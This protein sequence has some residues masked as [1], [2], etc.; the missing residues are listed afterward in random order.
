MYNGGNNYGN[1]GNDN[2]YDY[3]TGTTTPPY[4][5]SNAVRVGGLSIK[6]L[7]LYIVAGVVLLLVLF[8]IMRFLNTSLVMHFGVVAG[9]LLLLANVRELIGQTYGRHNNTALLNVLIGSSL[10]VAWLSQFLGPL[11]WIPAVLLL[12]IAAPLAIGRASVYQRYVQMGRGVVHQARRAVGR[13][14]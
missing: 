5:P 7:Y 3:N 9:A 2:G 4:T 10:V 6:P 13:W 11:L 14:N 8:F 1:G 12:A